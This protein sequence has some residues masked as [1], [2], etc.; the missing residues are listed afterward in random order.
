[1]YIRMWILD[2]WETRDPG[3]SSKF[4]IYNSDALTLYLVLQ[5]NS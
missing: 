4:P 2:T 3:L 1:M 5:S